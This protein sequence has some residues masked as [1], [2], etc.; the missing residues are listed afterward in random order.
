MLAMNKIYFTKRLFSLLILTLCYFQASYSQSTKKADS[1]N[2]K[3]KLFIKAGFSSD[4]DWSPYW[5]HNYSLGYGRNLWKNVNINIFYTHCQTNTLK[6][7][8][9]YNAFNYVNNTYIYGYGN[10]R[11]TPGDRNGLSVH[12]AFCVKAAYDFSV[13]KHFYIS[14]FLGVAYGWSKSSIYT[15]SANFD[16]SNMLVSGGVWFSYE[17]GKVFGPDMGMD[18]GYTFKNK[19]HQLFFEPELILLTAQGSQT[20]AD[21]STYEAIQLSIGYNY[22][23]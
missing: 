6:G 13:G 14:P 23:F 16:N 15:S 7:W 1:L 11:T 17:Q 9:H 22:K 5:G 2:Y 8:V 19:H 4:Y 10:L 12:D 3:N 21:G 18:V 20:I